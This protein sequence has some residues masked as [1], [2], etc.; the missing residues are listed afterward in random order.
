MPTARYPYFVCCLR[1][2]VYIYV[3]VLQVIRHQ[4]GIEALFHDSMA[5]KGL[6]VQRP[7][8][9]TSIE[10]PRVESD[11]GNPNAYP[12][13]VRAPG[14]CLVRNTCAEIDARLR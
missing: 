10:L 7:V 5:T 9:P 11:L 8:V 4:G 1:V 12:V 14:F 3:N 6:V 2:A 13:K